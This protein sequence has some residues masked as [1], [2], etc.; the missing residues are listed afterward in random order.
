MLRSLAE[1]GEFA[2]HVHAKVA[3][4]WIPGVVACLR[5]AAAAGE[6]EPAPVQMDL[7]G[8]LAHS[9]PL[10]VHML[11]LPT[12]PT[13]DFRVRR[14]ALVEQTAWFVLRGLGL[15]EAAIRRHYNKKT[16]SLLG[17]PPEAE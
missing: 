2:R 8:W 5:A 10:M 11:L 1:D 7:A 9:L 17:I 13:V 14:E 4:K 6:A 12:N 16:L 3:A 15:K